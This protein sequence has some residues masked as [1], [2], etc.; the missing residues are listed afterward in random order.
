MSDWC[1]VSSPT[2][3]VSWASW[4]NGSDRAGHGNLNIHR[5]LADG[6]ISVH[7]EACLALH[8]RLDLSFYPRED[9]KMRT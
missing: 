9:E 6:E 7:K 5:Q 2:N 3:S 1:L 4:S 8:I